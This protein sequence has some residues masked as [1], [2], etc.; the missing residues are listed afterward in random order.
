VGDEALLIDLASGSYFSAT[1]AGAVA[2]R[3][4][5]AGR[6][7]AET[8]ATLVERYSIDP[9]TTS[10]EVEAFVGQLLGERLLLEAAEAAGAAADN[11]VVPSTRP[12]AAPMLDKYTDL[13]D[14]ILLDPVHDVSD[15]GWPTRQPGT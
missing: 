7:V 3:D 6:T 13:S 15:A 8:A 5:A 11:G 4:L 2:W 14:L 12:Y 9:A 1:G 10:R